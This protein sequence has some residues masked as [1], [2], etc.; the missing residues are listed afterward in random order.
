MNICKWISSSLTENDTLSSLDLWEMNPGHVSP[1]CTTETETP[2]A[3]PR[4]KFLL[5]NS[6]ASVDSSQCIRNLT[7]SIT[8]EHMCVQNLELML[9][10]P[11]PSNFPHR[12][13]RFYGVSN[14]TVY[15]HEQGKGDIYNHIFMNT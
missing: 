14:D 13:Q 1:L 3:L 11:G 4:R 7:L 10:G 12:Q 2:I 15:Y 9:L 5:M 6:T 8:L